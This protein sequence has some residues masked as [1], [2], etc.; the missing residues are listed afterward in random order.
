M[1]VRLPARGITPDRACIG[2][3]GQFLPGVGLGALA[4]EN[5]R[6]GVSTDKEKQEYDCASP[7]QAGGIDIMVNRPEYC[8]FAL[9]AAIHHRVGTPEQWESDL[10]ALATRLHEFNDP[11]DG[12]DASNAMEELAES[13]REKYD[14]Q[15]VHRGYDPDKEGE[16]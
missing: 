10:L 11:I 14:R 3:L 5:L 8:A 9:A 7:P 4:V 15:A 6:R 16:E 13:F 2:A 1:W 12:S